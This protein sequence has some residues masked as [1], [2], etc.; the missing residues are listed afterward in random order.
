MD[1]R[2]QKRLSFQL[3]AKV[4]F[5]PGKV[6]MLAESVQE[7]EFTRAAFVVTPGRSRSGMLHP[8]VDSLKQRGVEAA[9]FDD[10]PPNPDVET[11]RRCVRF[12]ND[13]GADVVV[14]VG[15]GSPLDAAKAAAICYAN[16]EEDV[17][18]L[19]RQGIKRRTC[20]TIMI[21]TTAGT[22]SEVNYWSVIADKGTQQKVSIGDPKMAPY[23]ALVDPDLT[24]TLPPRQ[25]FMTGVDA[26]TH[27]VESFLSAEGNWLS[28]MFCVGAMSLIVTALPRVLADGAD[29]EARG[30]MSL[31]SL[32]AGAAMQN[33]GLGLIH[34][35]SHQL[36]GFYDAPHGLANAFLLPLVLAF[37]AP[38]CKD[39]LSTM[40][41][42]VLGG[43]GFLP[44]VEEL[45]TRFTGDAQEMVLQEGDLGVMAEWAAENVNARTNPRPASAAE[46][47]SLFR[48]CFAVAG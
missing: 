6:A 28:D 24:V 35:M 41:G 34:A 36:S 15:G 37:N 1:E 27:A 21:P 30:N 39:K 47:E 44:W 12:L 45:V 7:N 2:E 10:V 8:L 26:L 40:D 46:I 11:V 29:R 43:S 33:V 13:F 5:G 32:L 16:R 19:V 25:T 22:G 48:Q 20:P 4:E 17:L 3:P 14:A 42:L 9:V 31:G 38:C 23:M 18:Q